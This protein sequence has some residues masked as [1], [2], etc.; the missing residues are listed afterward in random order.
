M[1]KFRWHRG[2]REESELTSIPYTTVDDLFSVIRKEIDSYG[3]GVDTSKIR[4]MDYT[5]D[6]QIVIIAGYGVV[7]FI[8]ED[9]MEESE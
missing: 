4:I 6:H 9:E 5:S 3:L 1:N 8:Y 2:S 7:G